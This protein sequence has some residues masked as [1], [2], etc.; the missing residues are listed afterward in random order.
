[1]F[2]VEN[3]TKF[4]ETEAD[5]SKEF[6]QFIKESHLWSRSSDVYNF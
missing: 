2:A 3:G 4:K 1:M 5:T 6:L